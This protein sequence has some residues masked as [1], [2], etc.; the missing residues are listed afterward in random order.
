MMHIMMLMVRVHFNENS[1]FLFH[2]Q[3]DIHETDKINVQHARRAT[4]R[5]DSE[6]L[7]DK[8]MMI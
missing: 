2:S 1:H 6:M 7:V 3:R 8:C 4:I 5:N